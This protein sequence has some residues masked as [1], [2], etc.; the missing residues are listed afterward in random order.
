MNECS[1]ITECLDLRFLRFQL[2]VILSRTDPNVGYMKFYIASKRADIAQEKT[3]PHIIYHILCDMDQIE[4]PTWT[5]SLIT[6]HIQCHRFIFH[7]P[8]SFSGCISATRICVM[9]TYLLYPQ[10]LFLSNISINDANQH[11]THVQSNHTPHTNPLAVAI[12]AILYRPMLQNIASHH[13]PSPALLLSS[14]SM[15]LLNLVPFEV[16]KQIPIKS[17]TGAD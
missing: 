12:L 4:I 9:W 3:P 10:T 11:S 15:H 8:R 2:V 16:P 14:T 13:M 17:R 5:I 6:Q 1:P 7:L